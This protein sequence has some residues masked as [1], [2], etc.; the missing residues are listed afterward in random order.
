MMIGTIDLSLLET[1]ASSLVASL[2]SLVQF[3]HNSDS[4][5]NGLSTDS[6]SASPNTINDGHRLQKTILGQLAQLQSHLQQ[7]ADFLQHLA[8][9]NQLLACLRWLGDF[10]VLV[11]VPQTGSIAIRDV[12]DLSGTPEPQL[13]RIV[14]MMSTAGFLHQPQSGQVAHTAL[15]APFA[16]NPS[17]L[18]A[19]LFLSET[20]G[21]SALQMSTATQRFGLSTRMD[22]TAYN[23]ASG[24][25]AALTHIYLQRPRLQRQW[26]AYLRLG[27][28][29]FDMELSDMMSRYDW[30]SLGKATVVEV[31]AIS[32]ATAME[33]TSLHPKLDFIVQMCDPVSNGQQCDAKCTPNKRPGSRIAVHQR[34]PGA[35]QTVDD[36]AVYIMHVHTTPFS[37]PWA[38]VPARIVAELRANIG[39][40]RVNRRAT[41]LLV[42]SPTRRTDGAAMNVEATG[43][44]RDL[45][46][47]QLAN[48]RGVEMEELAQILSGMADGMGRLVLVNR[49]SAPNNSLVVFEMR[50]QLH[51]TTDR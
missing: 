29:D 20:A 6:G 42:T 7:P 3:C 46:L 4:F 41:L 13:A 11:L 43:R 24:N 48:G 15:S 32:A 45:S 26:R 9:Q 38:E 16:T 50:Y 1:Q 14:H 18:D 37:A 23:M 21:P 44:L 31:G 49:Y 28:G 36:A 17:L 22:E 12:A 5:M 47:W 33:L 2:Q 51:T 35:L 19:S 40:M 25:P 8:I 39:V 34:A 30:D 10:Q 27:F